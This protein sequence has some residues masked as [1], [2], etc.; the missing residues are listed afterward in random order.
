MSTHHIRATREALLA[1]LKTC[2]RCNDNNTSTFCD[3][4]MACLDEYAQAI[5][6]HPSLE[7]LIASDTN[8]KR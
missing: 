2:D 8:D 6:I 3:V 4:G 1:H 5:Q 7:L